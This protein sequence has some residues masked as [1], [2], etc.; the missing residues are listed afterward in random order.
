MK[1]GLLVLLFLLTGLV[2]YFL[3][4]H[5][6]KE[7]FNYV[8]LDLN[9]C[10][11]FV[12]NDQEEIIEIITLNEDADIVSNDL[13]TTNI[14]LEEGIISFLQHAINT[15][16]IDEFKSHNK[17]ILRAYGQNDKVQEELNKK[18]NE[19]ASSYFKTQNIHVVINSPKEMEEIKEKALKRKIDYEKMLLI[20]KVCKLDGSLK[21]EQLIKSSFSKL[22]KTLKEVS[23]KKYQNKKMDQKQYKN[24]IEKQ[25]V[26][27]RKEKE[28]QINKIINSLERHKDFSNQGGRNRKD[29]NELLNEGKK[30]VMEKYKSFPE[31]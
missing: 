14:T 23:L 22:Q 10:L 18:V 9:P 3:F 6:K 13:K 20:E 28:K 21:K 7:N 24:Y 29:I 2:L 1:K 31:T 8:I 30:A 19:M 17:L 27:K 11:E 5:S 16:Y 26:I 15:G 12:I 4:N 25:N